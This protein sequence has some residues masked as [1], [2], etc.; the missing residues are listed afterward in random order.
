MRFHSHKL[1]VQDTPACR[2]PALLQGVEECP[3][4]TILVAFPAFAGR[5]I[6]VLRRTGPVGMHAR[7]VLPDHPPGAEAASKAT[8]VER[9]VATRVIQAEA[10]AGDAE[11]LAGGASNKKVDWSDIGTRD[12]GEVAQVG[13]MG[14]A[15]RKHRTREGVDLRERHG[16]PAE[17]F[18][19]NACRLNPAAHGEIPHHAAFLRFRLVGASSSATRFS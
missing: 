5:D 8:K 6:F 1:S 2:I 15:M 3:E 4:V 9:Q 7:D 12:P 11:T 17:F 19:G 16:C 10:L 14:E 18:P 13:D